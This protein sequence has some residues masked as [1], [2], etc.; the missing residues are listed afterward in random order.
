MEMSLPRVDAVGVYKMTGTLPP[1][2]DLGTSAGAERSD[3]ALG[4]ILLNVDFVSEGS[5][6]IMPMPLQT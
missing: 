4:N 3:L 5:Q 6:R 1:N 2:I